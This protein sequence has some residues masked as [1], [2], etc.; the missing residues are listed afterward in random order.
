MFRFYYILIFAFIS[1]LPES[2]AQIE[3][4]FPLS[5]VSYKVVQ[6]DPKDLN[7]LWIHI[8]P[9]TVDALQMNTVIGTGLD[10]TYVPF[11]KL[12]LKG[13]IRGNLIDAFDLQRAS[14]N[15]NASIKTQESKR[16]QGSM[17]LTNS[18]SR[19]FTTELGGTY[20]LS[21][22][23]LDGTTKIILADQA[24]PDKTAMVEKIEINAKIRQI[25]GARLGVNSMAST[26]AV[27]QAIEDQSLSLKGDQG[28]I[29]NSKGT[30][31]SNGFKTDINNNLLFSNFSST[32]F[33]LGASLQR[34][35]NVSIKTERQGI[36]SDNKII[37]YYAD[38]FINPWT[39]L[40]DIQARNVGKTGSETFDVSPIKLNKIGGRAGFELRYNQASLISIGAEIGYRPA[41]SSQGMY[42]MLKLSF[43]T[44]S[45]GSSH[46][47]VATNVGSNQSL[48]Q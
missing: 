45:F 25:L 30:L 7:H 34:I 38:L 36:L 13:G 9:L 24:I 6:D 41:I 42:A 17:I 29:L 31:S 22:K 47:K 4:A 21:D 20:A 27:Q 46:Q 8:Q 15:R 19:F 10:I 11:P 35:K 32:G 14:A 18:F 2:S 44:F 48:S 39:K 23:L 16:E 12:E 26:V 28:T 33:Y 43:P 3:E 40:E 1:T 5:T 37:T